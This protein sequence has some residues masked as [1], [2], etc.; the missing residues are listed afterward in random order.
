MGRCF[1]VVAPYTRRILE[2]R[3]V[4]C[5]PGSCGLLPH[6]RY[7]WRTKGRVRRQNL[8]SLFC[9]CLR[10]TR[11]PWAW[12]VSSETKRV[13]DSWY[14]R[15]REAWGAAFLYSKDESSR[16]NEWW[17]ISLC[18][19]VGSHAIKSF[20][21][22]RTFCCIVTFSPITFNCSLV[23]EC[24]PLLVYGSP[25]RHHIL[26]DARRCC[27]KGEAAGTFYLM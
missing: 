10:R 9:N 27:S 21:F 20:S 15:W 13:I 1:S 6:S 7:K 26:L 16:G 25:P 18:N 8:S 22:S 5:S 14:L 17:G 23:S 12:E 4:G 11:R 3:C 24:H 19:E 2:H